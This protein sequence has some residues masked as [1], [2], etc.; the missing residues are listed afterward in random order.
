MVLITRRKLLAAVLAAAVGVL[1]ADQLGVLPTAPDE[2]YA[3][4]EA[5]P[6]PAP[7]APEAPTPAAPAPEAPTLAE[8]L[9]ALADGR[10]ADVT[11]L[12]DAFRAPASWRPELPKEQ[13][14]PAGPSAEEL[15]AQAFRQKHR[16]QATA[17]GPRGHIALMNSGCLT[18]GQELDGF[19]LVAVDGESA[20]FE[21]GSAKV[22][23][24]LPG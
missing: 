18:V 19:R 13:P 9:E 17:V 22:T 15:R 24:R 3:V 16:L 8:R 4:A 11:S 14:K 7:S 20:V 6:G 23:L 2:A 10:E 1:V 12:R 21:S 5:E